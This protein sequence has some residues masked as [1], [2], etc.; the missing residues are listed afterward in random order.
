MKPVAYEALKIKYTL[1]S[2]SELD[3]E[4][5][6]CS[7]EEENCTLRN[8][9]KK[10]HE[11]IDG[12]VQIIEK[13]I[14]PDPNSYIDL[15]E[16]KFFTHSEK[17]TLLKLFREMMFVSRT[18]LELDLLQDEKASADFIRQFYGEW[19]GMKKTL[20]P[21]ILNLKNAWKEDKRNKEKLDYLG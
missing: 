15:Y 17:D 6:I 16:C 11:R 8:I 7:I 21:I 3:A 19:L 12:A 1:P 4:F 5:E 2:F 10:I 13:I 20:L 14:Q 9:C 18:I